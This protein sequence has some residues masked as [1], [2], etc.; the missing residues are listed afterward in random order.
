[1]DPSLLLMD[2]AAR[3]PIDPSGATAP[4]LTTIPRDR[5]EPIEPSHLFSATA[6]PND[7]TAQG[8]GLIVPAN[9]D[10]AVL[11]A[12]A[13]LCAARA[14]DQGIAFQALRI[15]TFAADDDPKQWVRRQLPGADL[16]RPRYLL[17]LGDL[18]VLPLALQT[19]LAS[20]DY[21]VGRLA[22]DRPDQYRAYVDKLLAWSQPERAASRGR[23]VL[24]SAR[25]GERHNAPDRGHAD[26]MQ[27]ALALALEYRD[28]GQPGFSFDLEE[29]AAKV[30]VELDE[31]LAIAARTEIP[32]VLWTMSHGLGARGDRELQGQPYFG[33]ATHGEPLTPIHVAHGPFLAGGIW[34]LFACFG[35]GTPLQSVY[36]QWLAALSAARDPQIGAAVLQHA[37]QHLPG[38][39]QRPFVAAVPKAALAN[40]DGPLAVIGH[41]DLAWIFGYSDLFGDPSDPRER[42]L[43]VPSLLADP[44]RRWRAGAAVAQFRRLH[45]IDASLNDLMAAEEEA[46]ATKTTSTVD[47]VALGRLW[48]HRQDLANYIL[49]GDPAVRL[50]I[51]APG[52]RR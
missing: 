34:F 11:A 13:P 29:H 44:A 40:P 24:L 2:A 21:F 52:L 47:P 15:Y 45:E 9:G 10:P 23:A 12:V 43:R 6:D 32:T 19:V 7:L 49:L 14:A 20:Y 3:A 39:D 38:A 41:V 8:W 28:E 36:V 31:L 18:D 22:F 5:V 48:M 1:M 30:P 27:P 42:F 37:L 16:K 46:R 25:T 17:L 33:D 4:R 51:A 35:A 50:P 26:L